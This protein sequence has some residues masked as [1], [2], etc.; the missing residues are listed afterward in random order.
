LG[1]TAGKDSAE[2]TTG[3][4]G[5]RWNMQRG[6]VTIG[7][8]VALRHR[9]GERSPSFI[10]AFDGLQ[11]ATFDVAGS[12]LSVNDVRFG[13]QGTYRLTPSAQLFGN[14]SAQWDNANGHNTSGTAGIRVGF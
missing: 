12:P 8:D 10:A 9:F 5:V 14:V 11:S 13:L 7:S 3:E 2:T 4:L 6:K 1:L